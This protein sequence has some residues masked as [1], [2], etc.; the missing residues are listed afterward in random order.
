MDKSN[1]INYQT[2]NLNNFYSF[3][4]INWNNTYKSKK[5][6]IGSYEM[7]NKSKVLEI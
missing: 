3:K 7:N 6:I 2:E 4:R 1:N 5:A